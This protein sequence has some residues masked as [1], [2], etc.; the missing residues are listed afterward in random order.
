MTRQQKIDHLL[1]PAAQL[2]LWGMC[3]LV[4]ARVRFY[5]SLEP[6]DST[7]C[8]TVRESVSQPLYSSPLTTRFDSISL[9]LYSTPSPS[10]PESILHQL[11]SFSTP[12]WVY[13]PP[14][15][16]HSFSTPPRIPLCIVSIN[17]LPAALCLFSNPISSSSGSCSIPTPSLIP[18]R[19]EE[20]TS[21]LQSR[22]HISYAVFCLKKKKQ[23]KRQEDSQ[24][25]H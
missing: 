3:K 5:S 1:L 7:P 8:L 14:S 24:W 22:P 25:W 10:L 18:I 21:E 17:S 13:L 6:L 16:L 4:S 23:K 11:H 15:L 12:S 20:H 9:R 19:S 2:D